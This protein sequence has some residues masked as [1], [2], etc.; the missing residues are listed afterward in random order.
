MKA[1][2]LNFFLLIEVQHVKY[3][4]VDFSLILL[5]KFDGQKANIK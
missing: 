1:N 3:V 2:L 5:S 4:S